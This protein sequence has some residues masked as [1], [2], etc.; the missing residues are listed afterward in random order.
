MTYGDLVARVD[1]D[2]TRASP[3]SYA[4]N[5]CNR[6]CRNK[7]VRVN[8]YEILRLAR[9][10]GLST[11]EFLDRNTEAGGTV[12]RSKENGNCVFLGEHGCTVHPDR[13][14][15]CRIYPLARWVAADGEE[16]FGHLAPH[17][18]TAGVYGRSGTVREYLD[19]QG[20]QPFF[21][22][23]DRYGALYA[24]MLALLESL[25]SK[26]L[27][28]R[29]ERRDA[30]DMLPAGALASLWV[31]I[32]ASVGPADASGDLSDTVDR[33]IRAIDDWLHGLEA[34]HLSEQ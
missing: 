19:D 14:L 18:Q 23:G 30:V 33:H 9:R 7:A 15:A 24:K 10:L 17:P 22:I 32:D 29:Q 34:A 11:T 16:S 26:E 13:P 8:P 4:C 31:D 5:A 20:V 21:E 2:M 3:F 28:R 12:L 1:F 27:D 6:C 25:D